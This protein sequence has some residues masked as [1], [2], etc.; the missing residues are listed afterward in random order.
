MVNGASAAV[1]ISDIPWNGPFYA[2]LGFAPIPEAEVD[3]ALSAALAH[4]RE[5]GMTERIA[6]I[7]RLPAPSGDD[8]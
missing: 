5:L 6:M 8:S 1:L 4:E 3:A 7:C 2:S